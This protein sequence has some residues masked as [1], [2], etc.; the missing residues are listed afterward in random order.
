MMLS[1]ERVSE[2]LLSF[3]LEF[4]VSLRPSLAL[5]TRTSL[6]LKPINSTGV[7]PRKNLGLQLSNLITRPVV[8]NL[9]ETGVLKEE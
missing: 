9:C 4:I 6:P 1:R 7:L 3:K 5:T 8:L 2:Q